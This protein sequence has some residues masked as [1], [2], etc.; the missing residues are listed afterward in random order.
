MVLAGSGAML[1]GEGQL[2]TLAP[3]IEVGVTPAV[4]FAGAAQG[5]SRAAG[6]GVFAGMMNQQDSQLKLAL[7]FPQVREQPRDLAGVVFIHSVQSDQLTPFGSVLGS[8]LT[9]F[10]SVLGS[11]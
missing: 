7:E 4:E 2:G 11:K 1:G 6:V 3:H 10:G 5:L 9:P 8:K